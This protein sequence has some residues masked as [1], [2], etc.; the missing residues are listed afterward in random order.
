MPYICLSLIPPKFFWLDAKKTRDVILIYRCEYVI[1]TKPHK[2]LPYIIANT[3]FGMNTILNK[4]LLPLI[5][6]LHGGGVVVFPTKPK[7]ARIKDVFYRK[8]LLS[9]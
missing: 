9:L 2:A 3:V 8:W 5:N 7:I 4:L 1:Y 6:R